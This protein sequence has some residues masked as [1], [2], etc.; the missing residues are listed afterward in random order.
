LVDPNPEKNFAA[1]GD[2]CAGSGQGKGKDVNCSVNF[3]YGFKRD[4]NAWLTTLGTSAP[5]KSL[6]ELR[7]WNLSHAK[8][9]AIKYGQSR[10]DI[11]DEMDVQED[12][13]RNDADTKKDILLSRTNGI[14]AAL[15]SY[16]LD[17]IVTPRGSGAAMAARADYP[18]INVPFGSTPSGG[19]G[20]PFPDGFVP[21]PTPFGIDFIG[22]ACSEPNLLG[23]AY[24]FEQATHR[25]VPPP[26]FP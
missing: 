19:G 23:M 13:P 16:K 2:Y 22:T 4:F 26:N 3:K 17:A 6:T 10:L 24:A 12:G 9:G 20:E 5:V 11:S 15:T 21:K 14:E 1:W 18:I 7:Q 25:R 8:A